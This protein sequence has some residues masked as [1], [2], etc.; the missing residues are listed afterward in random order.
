MLVNK[1][2]VFVSAKEKIR[3]TEKKHYTRIYYVLYGYWATRGLLKKKPKLESA[4]DV[5][6]MGTENEFIAKGFFY[7][8]LYIFFNPNHRLYNIV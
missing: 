7:L 3:E 6:R 5:L 2:Y 4:F 8:Y 1:S